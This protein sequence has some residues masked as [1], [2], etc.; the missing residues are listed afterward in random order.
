MRP[1]YRGNA[2]P[3][4]GSSAK[5]HGILDALNTLV[6]DEA[7]RMLDMGLATPLMMSSVLR[8]HLDRRFCFGN[9][10]GS[11][12]RNQRTSATRSF[13]IEIDSTDA[14]P[15]IEQQFYETPAKA[16]FRCCNGY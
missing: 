10:A 4:V 15:P 13:A 7:D 11:H 14:L 12:R 1:Y 8:Q 5:R 2:G 3:F 16:K 6:M 9:L